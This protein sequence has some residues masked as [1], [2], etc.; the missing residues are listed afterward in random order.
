MLQILVAVIQR[1]NV[2]RCPLSLKFYHLFVCISLKQT[3]LVD[4]NL[5]KSVKILI[6]EQYLT[7]PVGMVSTNNQQKIYSGQI[8]KPLQQKPFYVMFL[9]KKRLADVQYLIRNFMIR[10]TEAAIYRCSSEQVFLKILQ[11]SQEGTC[12]GITFQWN[13]SPPALQLY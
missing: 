12:V 4:N 9:I 6:S 10:S 5:C 7:Y 3:L 11:C 1:F 8:Y 2:K 13:C